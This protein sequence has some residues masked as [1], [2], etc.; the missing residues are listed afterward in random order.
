MSREFEVIR[1]LALL[2]SRQLVV[3]MFQAAPLL[4]QAERRPEAVLA[5]TM[6][7]GELKRRHTAAGSVCP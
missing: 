6:V 2:S 3:S 7:R 1:G 4:R 5:L